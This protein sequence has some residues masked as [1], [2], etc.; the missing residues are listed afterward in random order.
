MNVEVDM[1]GLENHIKIIFDGIQL[2]KGG[3]LVW[4][5]WRK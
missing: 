2:M 4:I 5:L 1:K 3:H